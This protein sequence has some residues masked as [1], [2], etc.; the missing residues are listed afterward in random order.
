M[1]ELRENYL[2]DIPFELHHEGRDVAT[3]SN[4]KYFFDSKHAISKLFR[5]KYLFNVEGT[6]ISK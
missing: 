6:I 2:T 1:L 5:S 3:L 4:G